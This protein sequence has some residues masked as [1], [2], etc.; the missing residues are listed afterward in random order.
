MSFNFITQ[1]INKYRKLYNY[2]RD[3]HETIY[4]L[5]KQVLKN[6]FDNNLIFIDNPIDQFILK[7]NQYLKYKN[8]QDSHKRLIVTTGG[9]SLITAL[10][11]LKN[12]DSSNCEDY[13]IISG[14][15]G[16]NPIFVECNCNIA[17][18]YNFKKI[19]FF[20]Q[21]GFNYRLLIDLG[22]EKIDEIIMVSHLNFYSY[23]MQLY[24]NVKYTLF[25]EA[26]AALSYPVYDYSKISKIIIHNY[27]HKFDYFCWHKTTVNPNVECID[28]VVFD[29]IINELRLKYNITLPINP[30][31]KNILLLGPDVIQKKYLNINYIY[32][33]A[34]GL[35]KHGYKVF[36]KKHPRD[37]EQYPFE[38]KVVIINTSYPIELYDLS[39][40]A[41]VNFSVSGGITVPYFNKVAVFSY[42][43]IKG[44]VDLPYLH[45]FL[46]YIISQY[47]VPI[48]KLT[49]FDH[50]KYT[51]L[52]LKEKFME[53]FN[54]YIE[55]IPI[56]SENR[57]IANFVSKNLN[58]LNNFNFK[59]NI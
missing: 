45:G 44:K 3:I 26:P 52:E 22:L 41:I 34:K 39:V 2:F 53:I 28:K 6:N 21:K 30:D 47:I 8:K 49:N 32:K 10:S 12:L 11:I 16:T 57:N 5:D 25:Q 19:V 15:T 4:L 36:F 48:E 9:I 31:E 55:K 59:I 17:S 7:N 40:V 18:L 13:L 43:P 27:L 24:P 20:M 38:D 51:P 58:Q 37:T 1:Y 56:V 23:F 46:K 42:L 14:Y 54:D 50:R 33:I 29:G 35:I